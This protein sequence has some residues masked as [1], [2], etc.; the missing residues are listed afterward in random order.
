[1]RKG[2][3]TLSGLIH[4]KMGGDVRNG[5]VYI[6]V[7]RVLDTI[8]LLHAES[9]GLVLY[10]KKLEEGTFRLPKYDYETKSYQMTWSDLVMM[11][12]G[13]K[14]DTSSRQRRLRNLKNSW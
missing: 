12:E 10:Q 4:Q 14:E 5:D 8:K 1:M 13:I 6:F 9:G 11:V 7:N 3:F 2:M